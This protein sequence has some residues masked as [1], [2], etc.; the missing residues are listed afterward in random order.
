MPGL[1]PSQTVGPYFHV[2]LPFET[3]ASL[4]TEATLGRRIRIEGTVRDGAG[5]PVPDAL[6]EIWQA[7]AAGAYRHPSDDRG[8]VLDPAFDG[9]GRCPTDSDGRFTFDTIKPGAVP[10]HLGRPQAP[11]VLV[12]LSARGLLLHL[13]TRIY[14]ED[15]LGNS[16]DP[17]L[18]VIPEA[19][20]RTLVA[21][22]SGETY[23]FDIHL[24]GPD[25]TVFF[26]L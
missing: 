16:E 9:F 23:R 5:S 3:G 19:R 12:C 22:R 21:S 11:H 10:D 1:T 25:E 7:N 15:E 17:V 20:R 14:F 4:V 24:Q 6:V 8:V 2:G 18:G 13:Y 26:D